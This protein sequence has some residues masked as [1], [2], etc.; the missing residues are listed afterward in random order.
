[1][2]R[3]IAAAVVACLTVLGTARGQ[4]Y[5]PEEAVGRMTAADGLR[6]SLFAAEP[7]VRQPILVKCD[8]RGR[9]WVIQYL[10]YPNPA[11]LTRKKVDE[12][13]R[14]EYDRMP[15]PPP[16]GPRGADR[17]TICTDTDGDGRADAFRD[18]VTGLNLCTGLE[19]GHGGVFVIQAPYLLFYADENADDVPDGDPEVLLEGFGLE[20]SQSLAN[21]LTW[22]PDGWLYGVNGS[23]T[24]C[25]IRGIEFQQGVWRYHPVSRRFELFCEGGGNPYG[26]TFDAGGNLVYSSNGGLCHHAVQGGYFEKNFGKHGPLHNPHAYGWFGSV[27]HTGLTGRPNTGGI[28]YLAESFPERYRGAFMCGDFLGHTCSW[29]TVARE[30]STLA[31]KLGGFLLEAHD[32]SFGPTDLCLGPQGEVYVADFFDRRTAHPD[33]DADWDVETGRVYRIDARDPRGREENDAA[34]RR[35]AGI[36]GGFDIRTLPTPAL[37]ALLR[38]PNHWFRTRSRVELARRRD[39]AASGALLAAIRAANDPDGSLQ[40][41]WALHTAGGLSADTAAELLEHPGERVREWTVRLLGDDGRELSAGIAS[42]LVARAAVE[43]SVVVRAQLA[44][45]AQRLDGRDGLRVVEALSRHGEDAADPRIPDLLWWAIERHCLTSMPEALESFATADAWER[46]AL[47]KSLE[48]LL[49]RY[50]AAGT[51]EAAAACATLLASAPAAAGDGPLRSVARGLAERSGAGQSTLDG[52]LL[53]RIRAGWSAAKAAPVWLEMALHAGIDE[54]FAEL[55]RIVADPASDRESLETALGLMTRFGART[56]LPHV[57]ALVDPQR[58]D[59]VQRLALAVV[60]RA[61]TPEV[62]DRLLQRYPSLTA[63]RRSQVRD[64]L[65]ARPASAV[66]MLERV[67]A[68]VIDPADFSQDQLH[69]LSLLG[70]EAVDRLVIRHWGRMQGASSGE[71]LADIRRFNNDLRASA[72]DR[73][74]GKAL[75]AKHCGVCHTLFGEG[76]HVGPDLTKANRADLAVLLRNVVEPS[77]VIRK[78]YL[79]HV[80]TTADGQVFAGLLADQ[81]GAGITLLDARNERTWIARSDIDS[82]QESPVSLMPTGLLHPLT[83]QERRD[84]FAYLRGDP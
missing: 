83:P 50:A 36:D 66:A 20:D 3:V 19:F 31:L 23:T 45:T 30:A 74:A 78:E 4:N 77:H 40:A 53:E 43:P 11:G 79:T 13:S 38:H 35:L 27:R 72:G 58:P 7:A 64:V 12:W 21:H 62:D 34:T 70:D 54:A 29:W 47:R 17:I 28:F 32:A 18:F 8:D 5:P 49:R 39:P 51:P 65:L 26:L 37:V 69:R 15:E 48:R 16:R 14:T 22:G 57:L 56:A 80:V 10:Q 59:S 61:G 82:I 6:V 60:G 42:R 2:K 33:P 24:T 52:P 55:D 84:L 41:L 25:R 81:D 44:A 68:G 73:V 76:N 1:M 46:P 63:E 67:E 9:L 75:Y 71:T